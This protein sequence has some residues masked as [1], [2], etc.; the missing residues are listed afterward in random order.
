MKIQVLYFAGCPNHQ[1]AVQRVR[2]VLDKLGV[3]ASV[4]QVEVKADDDMTALKFTGS[5]TVLIEGRDIEPAARSGANYAFSCRTY[6]GSGV[7]PAP[8]VEQAIQEALTPDAH[9]ENG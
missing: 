5:P 8:M 9:E 4:E 2:E 7:P 6:S 1:P 3:A